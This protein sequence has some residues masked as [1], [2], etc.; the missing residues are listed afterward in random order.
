M[1]ATLRAYIA[2]SP[3]TLKSRTLSIQKSV[4]Q[5]GNLSGTIYVAPGGT[6]PAVRDRVGVFKAEDFAARAFNGSTSVASRSYS[7]TTIN[8]W[9]LGGW[10]RA[11][12]TSAAWRVAFGIGRQATNGYGIGQNPSNEWA[13]FLSGVAVVGAGVETVVPGDWVFLA[14]RR[15]S[16]TTQF[17][18]NGVAT[19]ATS[20]SAPAAPN[21]SSQWTVGAS[22]NTAASGYAEFF[23]GDV[24]WAFFTNSVLT[25]TQIAALASGGPGGTGISPDQF[26]AGGFF[27]TYGLQGDATENDTDGSNALTLTDTTVTDGPPV[28]ST[29]ATI[30]F[31]GEITK[32]PKAGLGGYS[33]AAMDVKIAAVDYMGWIEKKVVTLSRASESLTARLSAINTATLSGDG[34]TIGSAQDTGPT[35]VARDYDHAPL[36]Q[37]I[38]DLVVETGGRVFT[39][40]PLLEATMLAPSSQAAPFDLEDPDVDDNTVGDVVVDD[41]TRDYA[42]RVWLPIGSGKTVE[43][44][45]SFT[46]DGATDTWDLTYTSVSNRGYVTANGNFETLDRL[47]TAQ[48]T[49]NSSNQLVRNAGNL[50]NTHVVTVVHDAEFPMWITAE[51]TTEQTAHGVREK[52]LPARTDIYEAAVGQALADAALDEAVIDQQVI[53]YPTHTD[54]LEVG[55]EQTFDIAD[56]GLSTQTA[57]ITEL[58]IRDLGPTLLRYDV[59]A[60]TGGRL[61]TWQQTFQQWGG[62][63]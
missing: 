59:T 15:S 21:S 2:G 58:S 5:R 36:Q 42:N 45:E 29:A 41:V 18:V 39:I 12:S 28:V 7:D 43:V 11:D 55:M 13:G 30:L 60:I 54:G 25:T 14:L 27:R 8:D 50:T 33:V 9:T 10:V 44:T 16:G 46:G 47:G 37:V 56:R 57:T 52:T 40:S 63:A 51:N 19:G 4:N 26:D 49:I 61:R 48:W 24:A 31:A 23:D 3:V 38:N 62:V 22:Y 35:L 1:A 53:K 6:A 32:A 34:V 20:A 17:Y